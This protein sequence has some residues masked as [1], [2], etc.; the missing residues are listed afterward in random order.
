MR[1]K[2]LNGMFTI[3]TQVEPSKIDQILVRGYKSIICNRPD[4]EGE[5]QPSFDE[6]A[7]LARARGLAVRYIP[8]KLAGVTQAE[9][10][11]FAKAIEEMPKPILAYCRSGTRCAVLWNHFDAET[12]DQGRQ[13]RPERRVAAMQVGALAPKHA[14]APP[15]APKPAEAI[16]NEV[17]KSQYRARRH[18]SGA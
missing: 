8:V 4:G 16:R 14:S 9:H 1:I 3:A 12:S 13:G 5:D 7:K 17:F 10:A 18:S 11:A 2:R 15:P 6:V